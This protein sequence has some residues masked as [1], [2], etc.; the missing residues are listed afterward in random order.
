MGE[1][2]VNKTIKTLLFFFNVL[3]WL[4]GIALI[5]IGALIKVQYGD[6]LSI[7]DSKYTD[8]SIF[9]IV[10]GVIVMVMG[11]LGCV[12]AWQENYCMLVTFAVV[13]TII[14]IMQ[15]VGGAL[16][17]AYRGKVQEEVDGILKRTVSNYYKEAGSKKFMDWAQ[18]TFSCCGNKDGA[19]EYSPKKPASCG[20]YKVGCQKAFSSFAQDKMLIIGAVA[21]AIACIQVLGI[22]FSALL[23]KDV[24]GQYEVI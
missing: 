14:F 24:K 4:S 20:S 7:A 18:K 2:S 1:S 12:G 22:I 3:F 5:V 16:G 21:I 10:I 19:T 11:F 17:F 9:I 23:A 13:L 6:Y 8:I 15:I